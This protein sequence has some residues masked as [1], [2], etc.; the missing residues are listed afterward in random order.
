MTKEWLKHRLFDEELVVLFIS[1]F[2]NI[3]IKSLVAYMEDGIYKNKVFDFCLTGVDDMDRVWRALK[4]ADN[5]L[6][7][8]SFKNITIE[9]TE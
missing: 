4:P 6:H 3:G 7:I 1:E 2:T 8:L 9:Y 5:D